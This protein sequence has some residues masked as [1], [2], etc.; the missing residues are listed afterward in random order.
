MPLQV[1]LLIQDIFGANLKWTRPGA[2][3]RAKGNGPSTSTIENLLLGIFQR[4]EPLACPGTDL[5]QRS[6]VACKPAKWVVEAAA[7]GGKAKLLVTAS[8]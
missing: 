2:V 4:H 6:T 7:K 8:D 5:I 3:F 1:I